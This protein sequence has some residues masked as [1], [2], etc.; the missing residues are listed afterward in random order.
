MI[1]ECQHIEINDEG[2]GKGKTIKVFGYE[3]LITTIE[4]SSARLKGEW[5]QEDHTDEILN[6]WR[7]S[8]CKEDFCSE[9]GGHPKEWNYNYCP[10]CGAAMTEGGAK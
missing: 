8:N 4:I 7:C 1:I 2:N 10:N 5:M 3:G 9:V 6:I